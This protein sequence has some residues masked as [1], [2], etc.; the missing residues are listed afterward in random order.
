MHVLLLKP[1][2]WLQWCRS[3]NQTL[4]CW[5]HGIEV[6]GN[7]LTLHQNTLRGCRSLIASSSFTK[8]QLTALN[9]EIKV[10]HPIA[11]LFD[12]STKPQSLPG[13]LKLL[14]V[15]RMSRQ[16]K[17]KGHE[18]IIN[19]LHELNQQG[20][21]PQSLRW[22]VVGDGDQLQELTKRVQELGLEHRVCFHGSISDNE[23]R[24]AFQNCSI[25]LMPSNFKIDSLGNASGEGFGIVYLEAALAGR[26]SIGCN[27]GGQTDLIQDGETGWLIP[28]STTSLIN[29]LRIIINQPAL[30]STFGAKA[31]DYALKEFSVERFNQQ[32]IKAL[33]L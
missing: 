26:A 8:N 15:A 32:L 29:V 23:L 30:A 19:A 2:K 11:D 6:W 18:L 13:S 7:N 9:T 5:V 25:L 20:E 24:T 3:P 27:E 12:P 4:H 31:R 28:P 17:Y 33:E 1:V 22:D 10:V 21:L 16:E 14:T